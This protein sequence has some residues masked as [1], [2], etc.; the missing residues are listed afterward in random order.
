MSI[1][2]LSEENF[3]NYI[4]TANPEKQFSS[5][6]SGV[7]GSISLFANASDSYKDLFLNK[8]SAFSDENI[9]S[10]RSNIITTGISNS[11]LESYLGSVHSCPQGSRQSK[12]MVISRIEPGKT[13][14]LD[15]NHNKKLLI[16]NNL[17]NFYR[18]KYR[19]LN[20]AYTNYNSLNFVTGGNLTDNSVLIYPSPTGSNSNGLTNNLAPS[21]SFTFDFWINPR[22]TNGVPTANY[23]PGT[24]LHMSSC[25]AI[26]I[27]SGTSKGMDGKCD[28][29]RI[30]LQLSQSSEIPPSKFLITENTITSSYQG[31]SN[32]FVYVTKNNSLK[33]NNWHHVAIKWDG[34]NYNSRSGKILIDGQEN[35][36]FS[37]PSSSVMQSITP[38]YTLKDNPNALFIGNFYEGNNSGSNEI[39]NFFNTNANTNEGVTQLST[40]TND[41][42]T[43][44]FNH[45]LN[46]ELHDIKIYKTY[47]NDQQ[48]IT[49]S[50]S[51]TSLD[52]N[53]I[54]YLPPFFV[55][56]SR[57][58]KIGEYLFPG[59]TVASYFG[60][61]NDPFDVNLSFGLSGRKINLE[62]FTRDFV[63]NEY[64]R[65]YNLTGT[66]FGA[67]KDNINFIE[68]IYMTGSIR[69]A[70]L[71]I[72]PCDNGKFKPNFTL[73]STASNAQS[74]FV[75]AFG[76]TSLNL[77]N[78]D[79]MVS[80]DEL[81]FYIDPKNYK[82]KIA[83]FF[84][85]TAT[86]DN[87]IFY[88]SQPQVINLNVL[89]N[90]KDPSSNEVTIFDISNLFYGDKILPGTFLIE[91]LSV[92]GSSGR[93][94]FKVR[95]DENGSLY[96]ADSLTKNATWASVGNILYEEGLVLIKSPHMPYFGKDS[97]RISFKGQKKIYVFEISIPVPEGMFNSSSNPNYKELIPSDYV[98][99]ISKNFTYIT[100]INLHDDNLNVVMKTNLAQPL[101]KKE[102][103]KF[104]IKLRMDY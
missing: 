34:N 17:F 99:E 69:K 11:K 51:G 22:Y 60:K 91:D 65:L 104:L 61:T 58:R 3:Q 57:T 45:S 71:T 48:T 49:S 1:L 95:D 24:I 10:L 36:I 37:I 14:S 47:I 75:N 7:T 90:T 103:E 94:T 15:I 87:P 86:K 16:K 80:T 82:P 97:F 89:S 84:F 83:N 18:N 5:S 39:K 46:A 30:L 98:N 54:F 76:N 74:K 41:P 68:Q 63:N 31:I 78:L 38:N 73:L 67:T 81:T 96:R 29:F 28:G 85:E 2:K 21:S 72:L 20:W 33:L 79:N 26:S 13:G 101:I 88:G 50:L 44:S 12:K 52:S 102:R 93:M 62:N 64:P 4:L 66:S 40:N 43:S 27:V 35:T 53:L 77:I 25:Y 70:N 56:D 23:T 8:I 32:N 19:H 59:G 100:N 55:K 6:S 42:I 9:E 92:T